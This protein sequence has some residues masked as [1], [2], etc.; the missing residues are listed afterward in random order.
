MIEKK[1]RKVIEE[2]LEHICSHK[3]FVNSSI[4]TR[5]LRYLVEKAF[6]EEDLKEF[7]I[8]M[9]LWGKDYG[10][11]KNDGVVRSYMYKLRKKL[12][13]YYIENDADKTIIFEIKKGQYNLKFLTPDVYKGISN[14]SKGFIKIPIKYLKILGLIIFMGLLLISSWYLIF[15]RQELCWRSFFDKNA[16]NL[17]IVSDQ[18]MLT[19]KNQW[20]EL[21]ATMYSEINSNEEYL[22]YVKE[23]PERNIA[24]TDYTLL[25]QMVPWSIKRLS[26]W[27]FKYKS[28]FKLQFESKL[29]YKE[30]QD[31]NILF[32]GQY[33]SMNTSKSLFL[34]NSKVFTMYQDGFKYK[35]GEIEKVYNT[36]YGKNGKIEYAM[37]S[38]TS[39]SPNNEALYFVSNNDIG[40]IATLRNFTD[41]KW[42]K[43]FY[44]ILPKNTKYFNALY[45]VKG[46]Q[47]TDMSCKLMELEVIDLVVN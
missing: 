35:E 45:E 14:E 10:D 41:S 7:T 27:F 16:N 24:T 9:D 39:L 15:E 37:V 36:N 32:I 43:E 3:L 22:D 42:L 23:H 40:V 4:N 33:K 13:E 6:V 29:N 18:F 47:R 26:E 2:A 17:V 1:D 20:D 34:K 30:I 31:N 25:S 12:D 21:H 8:G 46:M 19:E 44:K 38:F 28:D 11:D 5:L